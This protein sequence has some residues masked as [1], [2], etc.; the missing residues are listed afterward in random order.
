MATSRDLVMVVD[1]DPK[2]V[3]L[4]RAYLISGGFDVVTAA[5]GAEALRLARER[6]LSSMTKMPPWASLRLIA[7]TRATDLT[8]RATRDRCR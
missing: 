4:V 3:A 6:K 1:D 2:I 8:T 7:C 5:D